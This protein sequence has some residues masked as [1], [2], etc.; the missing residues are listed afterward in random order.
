MITGTIGYDVHSG[1][2]H[3]V[4]SFYNVGL[5]QRV[6]VI[7]HPHYRRHLDWYAGARYTE[8][9][10]DR[11]LDGLDL[12][13]LFEN[14]FKWD[15]ARQ[16]KRRGVK[17]VLMPNYEYTPFPPPV[18]PD[19]V[20]CPS[21]LDWD[22]YHLE[23][24]CKVMFCPV[25]VKWRLRERARVFV[26]NAGHG[27]RGFAKGTPQ[28]LEAMKYVKS[29]LRLIVRGQPDSDQVNQLL[30][31]G[32][33]DPRVEIINREVSDEEL[34]EEGDVFVQPEQYN[35]MSLMLQEAR[36]AGMLVMTTDRYPMNVWLPR[37]PMIPVDHYEDDA[38]AVRFKR[39][40]V[41][42]QAIARTMDLWYDRDITDYSKSGRQWGL[43]CS[44]A[45]LKRWFEATFGELV[46]K[47]A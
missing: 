32:S 6:L 36:A 11:F 16:A 47:G 37:E 43:N 27:Q 14:A 9:D 19:L 4:R 20:W 7:P 25:E 3:L 18:T 23:Y 35:G 1:L 8:N 46:K 10:C 21:H 41:T 13:L 26:H 44:W 34:W 31:K 12:L 24:P 29:P 45:N 22:Y 5:V 38:I 39:A 33:D 30:S 40:V 2:G 28:L 42:P 15:I 17:I